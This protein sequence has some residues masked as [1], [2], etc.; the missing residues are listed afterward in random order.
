MPPIVP[1]KCHASSNSSKDTPNSKRVATNANKSKCASAKAKND[2]RPA[3]ESFSPLSKLSSEPS[4]SSPEPPAKRQK[5]EPKT[6]QKPNKKKEAGRSPSQSESDDDEEDE[7]NVWG[8]FVA[9]H[10]R[11]KIKPSNQ[12]DDDLEPT[13]PGE[14][15]ELTLERAPQYSRVSL[16]NVDGKKK[17]PSKIEKLIRTSA[18][19]LHVQCLMLHN[20]I[21]NHWACDADVH[22]ILLR[23][24]SAGCKEEIDK[25]REACGNALPGNEEPETKGLKQQKKNGKYSKPSKKHKNQREW[26]HAAGQTEAGTTDLSHGD[27]TLRLLQI[28]SKY[29][30]KKFSITA[31]GLRKQG[32]KD[33]GR[34]QQEMQ[35]FRDDDYRSDQH[36]ER[37]DNIQEFRNLAKTCEGSRDVGAQLFTALL[38]AI[39]LQTRLVSNLQPI[40]FG[41]SKNEEANPPKKKTDTAPARENHAQ[42]AKISKVQQKR[43]KNVPLEKP[44]KRT[45]PRRNARASG[46]HGQ[47]IDLSDEN[48]SP[49][50]SPPPSDDD[51]S[52]VDITP[53]QPT[54][55][56]KKFDRD[57]NFPVYWTEVLS[58]ISHNWIP[59]DSIWF[60]VVASAR[61][62]H[63]TFEP[64]GSKADKTKQVIG[65]V[66]GFASDG[67]AKDL[68]VRYL[69]HHVWP[70]K[71]KGIR[72]PVEK[73]PVYNKAG[74][75]KRHEDRDWF[76]QVLSLYSRGSRNRTTA[77]DIE[78]ARDLKP[79]IPVRETAK[80]AGEETLQGY[81][82]SAEFVLERHL[83]REEAVLPH[84]K[85]VKHF[86]TGKG[87]KAKTEPVFRRADVA[88]CRTVESWHKEGRAIKPGAQPLKYVPVR[89]VTLL[90]KREIEEAERESGEKMKQALYSRN[91]TDWII[92]PP[93]KNGVI[94][95]NAFG[96]MDVY[97]PTMVPKG[98]V[99]V[100]LRATARVCKRLGIDYA[101]ACTG[102]EFGNKRA[103][104]VLT[105][106]VVAQENEDA[107][108]DAWE[109]EE[110]AR[111]KRE[112]S[113]RE[114]LALT[115]W[116]KMYAGLKIVE[117]MKRE[118]GEGESVE[119]HIQHAMKAELEKG[120]RGP[121]KA[122]NAKAENIPKGGP[123][124][125]VTV[126]SG[127]EDILMREDVGGGGFLADDDQDP[128]GTS[129]AKAHDHAD[130][131]EGGGFILEDEN[132][133]SLYKNHLTNS[134]ATRA[135]MSLS[136][137][138][139]KQSLPV[140]GT[141]E[142]EEMDFDDNV[143]GTEQHRDDHSTDQEEIKE[144][145]SRHFARKKDSKQ[146]HPEQ[147]GR[148][149]P[150]RESAATPQRRGT[151]PFPGRRSAT[152]TSG[153]YFESDNEDLDE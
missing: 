78:D 133:D 60:G 144:T 10:E 77:D 35:G 124:D 103:V 101:E 120:K 112:E 123:S 30:Q 131:V 99:H 26:G 96:N 93:I 64:R 61:G 121:K 116:K 149:R 147:K 22:N 90:R 86:T 9:S 16:S 110:E 18:H 74:K 139:H 107:L 89:A 73:I 41:F 25:W 17:G 21:R 102:F 44:G 24:L 66:V 106:V 129:P 50:S 151:R 138:K 38:R 7:D 97:V 150:K 108:I 143:N 75:I 20:F 13:T 88:T 152:K 63:Y 84:A 83:R 125:P 79:E 54:K 81:K 3:V 105:G 33:I 1:R 91:Q 32:W 135:P 62:S 15:L 122:K 14:N 48:E 71:T 132:E 111:V 43:S 134:T 67:T 55:S 80:N 51:G 34:L 59:V 115:W 153:Y 85:P 148:G 137:L 98:A 130:K 65:Y 126:D 95:K 47:P 37:L 87:D 8:A 36:G 28:L 146:T 118:Y 113:K 53:S 40:G 2:T 104:P 76:K 58:P 82:N 128:N 127:N 12:K 27:P 23:G 49:L 4:D 6:S 114:K 119:K 140:N 68:T 69:K 42:A 109:A 94:P 145:K 72:F 70:G 29:W 141:K 100:P 92:P 117:R 56:N 142:D 19:Q 45:Q 52:V 11:D 31:H 136:S 5:V 46:T 39:G 57:L